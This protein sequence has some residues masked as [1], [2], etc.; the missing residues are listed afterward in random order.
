MRALSTNDHNVD[1]ACTQETRGR[2]VVLVSQPSLSGRKCAHN[3]AGNRPQA[4]NSTLSWLLSKRE[5][6]LASGSSGRVIS[7]HPPPFD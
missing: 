3:N 1:R 7:G 2:F 6:L 5:V 4:S